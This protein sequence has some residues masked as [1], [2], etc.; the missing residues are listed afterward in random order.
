MTK[1][2]GLHYSTTKLFEGE[3]IT[4][5]ICLS[6]DHN[7]GIQD[8]GL[9]AHIYEMQHDHYETV[10]SGCCHEE[11]LKHWPE[12]K[13][14]ADLHLSDYRGVPM[15]AVENGFYHIQNYQSGKKTSDSA[16]AYLRISDEEFAVLSACDDKDILHYQLY[17]LGIVAKWEKEAQEAIQI[18]EDLTGQTFKANSIKNNIAPLSE[19]TKTLIQSRID[20][21]YY[22]PE[23]IQNR[24]LSAR[25]AKKQ[26]RIAELNAE[27]QRKIEK[28]R[29]E[30]QIRLYVVKSGLSD[31]NFIYYN[32]SNTAVFNWKSGSCYDR[33]TQEAFIDFL[34][35]VDYS[36]LPE[37]IEFKLEEKI[38]TY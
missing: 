9:T 3:K 24:A 26:K 23:Q 34:E 11:I 31:D 13:I 29:N 25:E 18:L 15:Y 12:F 33:I 20:A 38:E 27:A 35:R 1:T 22:S 16:K 14:F 19:Q 30:L 36:Q 8:F 7:N 17:A 21:G 28:I 6:D 37:G 5:K 2:K 10:G 32:H 4:V